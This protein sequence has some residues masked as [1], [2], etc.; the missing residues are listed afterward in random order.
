MIELTPENAAD[1]LRSR[2]WL[3][4]GPVQ[5]GPLGW[6]VSNI[7]LRVS[8]PPSSALGN[9]P[10]YPP[11]L[12]GGEARFVLK[13]SRPQLRTREAWFSNLDRV[14]REAA[15]M[16]LLGPLLPPLTVPEVLFEDRE[17]YVFAMSHAPE[18]AVVWKES[19]LAGHPPYGGKEGVARHAGEV[20][21]LIHE[22][23]ANRPDL[24]ERFG[25]RT[26]F[27]QLRIDP[28]YERVRERRPEVADAITPLI[29][30]LRTRS[31]AICHGDFSPKNLL[32]HP[33]SSSPPYQ[34]GAG[35]G[36]FTLVD[37]ETAHCGDPTM[38]PGFFLSHLMLKA[39]KHAQGHQPHG[40]Q[41]AP[42]VDADS[43]SESATLLDLTRQ[44]WDGYSSVV[45]FRPV[46]EL[47]ARAIP[48]FAVCALARID[49]T[50]PV[51][52]LPEENKRESVRRIAR[53]VLLAKPVVW[54]EVLRV[55]ERELDAL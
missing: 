47:V 9:D 49:G 37:Y 5:V 24:A 8:T 18:G 10:P 1:Y 35:G 54:D 25:D 51:D 50:S 12:R 3:P 55:I 44:F 4:P 53:S 36:A 26:V 15:L 23:T 32:V 14:Y 41:L 28:F 46:A 45:R 29:E 13:Q 38:D 2:G 20:L 7:V 43:R 31:Q 16:R 21:G 6:G 19:L 17:N 40:G 27:E 22:R 42:R 11:L 33:P 39:V 34:G 48:H 30:N 52:Y